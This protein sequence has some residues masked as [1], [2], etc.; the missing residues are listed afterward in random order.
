MEDSPKES[1]SV[2]QK[3]PV[4]NLVRYVP[5][6]KFFARIRVKGRLIRRFLKT[7]DLSVARLRLADLEKSERQMAEHAV[8]FEKLGRAQ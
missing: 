2:W 7:T 3:T 4:A 8:A 1:A 5:S 6:G